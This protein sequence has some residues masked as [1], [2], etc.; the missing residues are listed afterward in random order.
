MAL[1][2][3]KTGEKS[4]KYQKRPFFF[5]NGAKNGEKWRKISKNRPFFFMNGAK[6]GK[7]MTKNIKKGHFSL[8]MALKMAK[9]GENFQKRP[10]FFRNG[11]KNGEK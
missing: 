10:F 2:I 5:K 3:P 4:R 7:K 9:N 8:R 11:A 6:N 1:K